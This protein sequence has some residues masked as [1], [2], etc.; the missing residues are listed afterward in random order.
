MS[1]KLKW[2]LII[3]RVAIVVFA[4]FLFHFLSRFGFDDGKIFSKSELVRNY[5]YKK[6]ELNDLK[7]FYN[8]IVPNSREVSIEFKNDDEIAR[9]AITNHTVVKGFDAEDYFCDWNLSIGSH[10]VDSVMKAL[11][12]SKSTLDSIKFYL[13]RANCIS[14]TNGEP[15]NIGFQRSGLGMYF[16][17]LFS[18]A[19]SESLQKKYSD[20]CTYILY[21]KRVVLEYGGGAIGPQCFPK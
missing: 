14:V 1:V 6:N 9:L 13:D 21:N 4:S 19:I 3:L 15:T 2:V 12:W 5:E 18:F 17:N 20:S 16:Y 10:T 7:L 8:Q 11:K